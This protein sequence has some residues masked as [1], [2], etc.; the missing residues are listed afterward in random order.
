MGRNESE[1]SLTDQLWP[2]I[3]VTVDNVDNVIERIGGYSY[4]DRGD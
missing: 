4:S 2:H 3:V 1:R